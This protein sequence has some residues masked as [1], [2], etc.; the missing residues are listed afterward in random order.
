[1]T[2]S[3]IR[4]GGVIRADVAQLEQVE[5]ADFMEAVDT[6]MAGAPTSELVIHAGYRPP[7]AWREALVESLE[8]I[9]EVEGIKVR[10]VYSASEGA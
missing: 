7:P 9:V 10:V 1:M 6:E 2:W 8:K 5:W 3:V 4:E